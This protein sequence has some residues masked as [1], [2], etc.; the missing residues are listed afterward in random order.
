MVGGGGRPEIDGLVVSKEKVQKQQ[1][2]DRMKVLGHL[3]EVFE[4]ADE[5]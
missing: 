2:K 3:R 4:V 1:E 5:D